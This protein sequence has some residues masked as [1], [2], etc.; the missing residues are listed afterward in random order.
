MSELIRNPEDESGT[1]FESSGTNDPTTRCS[2][3]ED[4]LV[5]YSSGEAAVI[6]SQRIYLFLIVIS[7]LLNAFYMRDG[8]CMNEHD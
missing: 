5:Q 7:S 4:L 3:P 2:D 1:F 8:F 6:V